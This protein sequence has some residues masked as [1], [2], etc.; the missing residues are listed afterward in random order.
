MRYFFLCSGM[1]P[2]LLPMKN[3]IPQAMIL[4]PDGQCATGWHCSPVA[5][6]LF[7]LEQV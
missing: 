5:P 4:D 3:S 2:G 6:N 7:G 1:M